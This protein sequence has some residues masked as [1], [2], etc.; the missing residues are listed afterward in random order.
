MAVLVR[1]PKPDGGTRHIGIL[2]SV[3]RILFRA[4]RPISAQWTSEHAGGPSWGAGKGRSSSVSAY[5]LSLENEV[6]WAR[7]LK[8]VAL[9]IDMW[10]YFELVSPFVLLREAAAAGDPFGLLSCC[11]KCAGS[12][13]RSEHVIVPP[14]STVLIRELLLNVLM[15]PLCWRHCCTDP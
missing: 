7:D 3:V 13:E 15:I 14:V 8:T 12:Q 4:R 2:N 9:M 6:A 10:K 1:L 11:S 5:S